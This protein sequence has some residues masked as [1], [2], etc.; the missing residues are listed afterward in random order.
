MCRR[1]PAAVPVRGYEEGTA[2]HRCRTGDVSRTHAV[3]LAGLPGRAEQ[4]L[5]KH[6]VPPHA[7]HRGMAQQHPHLTEAEGA[8]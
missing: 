1:A 6:R 8:A 5:D 4:L 3:A 7:V 2:P